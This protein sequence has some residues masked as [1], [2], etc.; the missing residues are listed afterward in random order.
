MELIQK[1]TEG[2]EAQTG[3]YL[4]NQFQQDEVVSESRME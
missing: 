4:A 1:R 3:R 2:F